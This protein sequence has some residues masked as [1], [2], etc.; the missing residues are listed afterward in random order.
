M[1]SDT[2]VEEYPLPSCF[3]SVLPNAS[4]HTYDDVCFIDRLCSGDVFLHWRGGHT[5]SAAWSCPGRC[6]CP[7]GLYLCIYV[8]VCL[9]L[10]VFVCLCR[11][12]TWRC[13]VTLSFYYLGCLL[14]DFNHQSLRLVSC[15]FSLSVVSRS[16]VQKHFLVA[17]HLLTPWHV[18]CYRKLRSTVESL[19]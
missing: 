10:F 5:T 12:V 4:L 9:C 1:S 11:V 18:L 17:W 16:C 15:F 13:C 7:I 8:Y 6:N 19:S 14:F 3:T 2:F